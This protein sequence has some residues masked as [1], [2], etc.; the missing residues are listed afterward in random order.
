[1]MQALNDRPWLW[2]DHSTSETS[3]TAE[4]NNSLLG[5]GS[6]LYSYYK[7]NQSFN[8]LDKRSVQYITQLSNQS[9]GGAICTSKED[10]LNAFKSA[11]STN[12]GGISL[13]EAK[14]IGQIIAKLDDMS[15]NLEGELK[16]LRSQQGGNPLE[17]LVKSLAKTHGV[18]KNIVPLKSVSFTI[19][20]DGSNVK[21]TIKALVDGA[22]TSNNDLA[23]SDELVEKVFPY[24]N[25][26]QD[27]NDAFDNANRLVLPRQERGAVLS[28]NIYE[29][30]TQRQN[31][32]ANELALLKNRVA[33]LERQL[34]RR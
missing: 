32:G 29:D 11:I 10:I 12:P 18:D 25:T 16:S 1:L 4:N 27:Y 6:N 20:N 3:E 17:D 5:G 33:Q 28:S 31:G 7:H 19:S 15:T 13:P 22:K 2:A 26:K 14:E 21:D 9:G 24:D 34:Q 30:T 8:K 23:L